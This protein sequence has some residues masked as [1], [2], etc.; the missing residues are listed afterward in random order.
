M[1]AV[2]SG[3]YETVEALLEDGAGVAAKNVTGSTALHMGIARDASLET[4]NLL[5]RSGASAQIETSN[6]FG[7]TP[8]RVA[9]ERGREDIVQL[10]RESLTKTG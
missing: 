7:Y 6:E 9:L 10:L 2:S 4:I 1:C 5:L 3:S 8:L